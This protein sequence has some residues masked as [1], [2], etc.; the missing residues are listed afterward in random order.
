MAQPRDVYDHRED[1]LRA[2]IPPAAHRVTGD[3]QGDY[4]LTRH[5]LDGRLQ[6]MPCESL[7]LYQREARIRPL[8]GGR[9]ST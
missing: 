5:L 2:G 7:G 4:A 8:C 9:G 1:V 3:A 6:R